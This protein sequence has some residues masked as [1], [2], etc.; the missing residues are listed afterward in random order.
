MEFAYI[1]NPET[2]RKVN[3]NGLIGR[4]VI[5]NYIQRVQTGGFVRSSSRMPSCGAYAKTTVS[6][7]GSTLS[8]EGSI[9]PTQQGGARR[10]KVQKIC[11][12]NR[13]TRRCSR[14]ANGR[15][16]NWCIKELNNIILFISLLDDMKAMFD[17][18]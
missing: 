1:V 8:Q 2:G 15:N 7:E 16:N 10:R 18:V 17:V 11:G 6:Q 14:L 13:Q 5:K 12:F 9:V 3:I 4:R